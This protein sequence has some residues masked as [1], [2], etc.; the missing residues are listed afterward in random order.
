MSALT[1]LCMCEKGD[2]HYIK[3]PFHQELA[4]G[5]DTEVLAPRPDKDV[6]ENKPGHKSIYWNSR[7]GHFRKAQIMVLEMSLPTE[8][9]CCS[10]S[11]EPPANLLL[12]GATSAS[13]EPKYTQILPWIFLCSS[14]ASSPG[15]ICAEGFHFFHWNLGKIIPDF[16]FPCCFPGRLQ[17]LSIAWVIF[18]LISKLTVPTHNSQLQLQTEKSLI[19]VTIQ[20]EENNDKSLA[21]VEFPLQPFVVR[22][23]SKEGTPYKSGQGLEVTLRFVR[24]NFAPFRKWKQTGCGPSHA[25]KKKN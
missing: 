24:A 1:E 16:A 10:R 13:R 22:G 2:F 20:Q 12:M 23:L 3:L 8:N 14:A 4:A 5:C 7:H 11:R 21:P 25:I 9:S 15:G 18:L 19:D 6:M 17:R